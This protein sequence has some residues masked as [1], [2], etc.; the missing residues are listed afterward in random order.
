MADCLRSPALYPAVTFALEKRL[1]GSPHVA[2]IAASRRLYRLEARK[3]F[4]ERFK[5]SV[6]IAAQTIL[7][8]SAISARIAAC[9]KRDAGWIGRAL[10]S[11]ADIST[12][13]TSYTTSARLPASLPPGD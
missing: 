11:I 4:I 10:R 1:S 2:R 3:R 13:P 5:A 12:R 9:R 6:G 8:H 7:P